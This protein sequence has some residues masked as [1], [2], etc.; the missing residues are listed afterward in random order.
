[1]DTDPDSGMGSSLPPE[2][3]FALLLHYLEALPSVELE[4]AV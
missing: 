4:F 3:S 2:V 1:M